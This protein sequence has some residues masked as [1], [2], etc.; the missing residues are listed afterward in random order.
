MFDSPAWTRELVRKDILAR[1]DK[2]AILI[3]THHVDDVEIISDRVWFLNERNL[4]FNGT[5]SDLHASREGGSMCAALPVGEMTDAMPSVLEFA[6]SS[7]EVRDLFKT[8]FPEEQTQ[9]TCIDANSLYS[10]HISTGNG[11]AGSRLHTFIQ[12]LEGRGYHDWSLVSPNAYRALSRMYDITEKTHERIAVAAQRI[13]TEEELQA[14]ECRPS[15]APGGVAVPPSSCAQIRMLIGLRVIEIRSTLSLAYI[16]HVVLPFLIILFL[17]FACGD[18]VFPKLELSSVSI[19]G[20]GEVLVGSGT[21]A[22]KVVDSAVSVNGDVTAAWLFNS[23]TTHHDSYAG[24]EAL[25]DFMGNHLTWLGDKSSDQLFE[26]LYFEYFAHPEQPRWASFVIDDTVEKWFQSTVRIRDTAL[27]MPADDVY[28]GL[29][30]VHNVICNESF[31]WSNFTADVF[32][33]TATRAAAKLL[34]I[35][36]SHSLSAMNNDTYRIQFCNHL[37][38]VEISLINSR[39]SSAAP[40]DEDKSSEKKDILITSYQALH[41]NLTMMT[42]VTTDH[43]APIFL[44]EMASYIYG[45]RPGEKVDKSTPSYRWNSVRGKYRLYSYPFDDLNASSP[46]YMQRGYLGALMTILYILMTSTVVVKFITYS[47]ASGVKTQLHLCGVSTTVY[48]VSQ[49]I[50]DTTLLCAPLLSIYMAIMLGG[51]PIRDFFFDCEPYPGLV[52]L[53]AL[54]SYAAASVSSNFA[55]AVVSSDQIASQLLSLVTTICGGLF[56][57]LF[58]IMNAD[59]PPYAQISTVMTWIAPSFALSSCL[60]EMFAR[61]VSQVGKSVGLLGGMKPDWSALYVPI[62]AMMVQAGLYLFLAIV[63]DKYWY[64]MNVYLQRLC[65]SCGSIFTQCA[66]FGMSQTSRDNSTS[67]LRQIMDYYTSLA[68]RRTSHVLEET[69]S[70]LE[71]THSNST[72]MHYGSC[73]NSQVSA[74]EEQGDDPGRMSIDLD[75]CGSSVSTM[76]DEAQLEFGMFPV[77]EP[78]MM[79]SRSSSPSAG[80]TPL[81]QAQHLSVAYGKCTAPIIRDLN[82]SINAGDRVAL[83]GVNGGGKSTLFKTLS[84]TDM[85]PT[86][87][88]VSISDLDSVRDHWAIAEKGAVGYVPQDGG[89]LEFMTVQE[90]VDLFMGLRAHARG[91]YSMAEG[92]HDK[93]AKLYTIMPKKY[94]SYTIKSLSGGNKRKLAVVLSN[95][96]SPDMLLLDEPSSGVDPAA[97]ERIVQ[98]LCDLPP[99]QGLL[100]ASHRLDECLRVCQRVVMLLSGT[101]QF[102]GPMTALDSVSGLF[103]QVD[104]NIVVPFAAD[105]NSHGDG[106]SAMKNFLTIMATTL[107]TTL[108]SPDMCLERSVVYSDSLVRLTLE[109]LVVPYSVAWTT[110]SILTRDGLVEKYAYRCMDMEEIFSIMVSSSKKRNAGSSS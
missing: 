20:V 47:R 76:L 61:Y 53:V 79:P 18:V 83:M 36:Q 86:A 7:V 77:L 60:F 8:W 37:S 39:N 92:F 11:E 106:K 49:F 63:L 30:A 97:A 90:A 12:Y 42:N 50:V 34:G 26:A 27:S 94:F 32:E 67:S 80:D 56:M 103:Y 58:L 24:K 82:V 10:C 6:T 54:I 85:I 70:L 78:W 65:C 101:K 17:V 38:S 25:E 4:I 100:F 1:K 51:A 96:N 28:S 102:D 91:G 52:F 19:G 109:K 75:M 22:A 2:C 99:S 48:W 40:G 45:S 15:S 13:D 14:P 98:Y 89:L 105:G 72:T 55:F 110:L 71:P 33:L 64:R 57:K 35:Q 66:S 107:G 41:S 88:D 31:V 108:G 23:H 9:Q 21:H 104:V 59:K 62:V 84:T 95:I 29:Q 43:G 5:L 68:S 93:Y 69:I 87:G 3:S 81:I 16:S 74:E 44:K 73:D 46:M